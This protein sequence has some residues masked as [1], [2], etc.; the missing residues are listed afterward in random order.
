MPFSLLTCPPLSRGYARRNEL[1]GDHD[2]RK[3]DLI[4]DR[5]SLRCL[6]Q[7]MGPIVDGLSQIGQQ[8]EVGMNSANDNPLIDAVNGVSYHGGNFLGQYI[9][10]GMDQ[11]RLI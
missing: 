6:P 1:N 3:D 7:Y 5:Y 4:Q 10:V 2:Y 9:G 11:L 8:I